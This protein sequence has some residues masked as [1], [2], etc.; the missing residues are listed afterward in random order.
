MFQNLKLNGYRGFESYELDGLTRVNLLVGKNNCGKTSILEAINLLVSGGNPLVLEQSASRRGEVNL[1]DE[2]DGPYRRESIPDISHL[3]FGHAFGSGSQF[4]L[5]SDSPIGSLS[6]DTIDVDDIMEEQRSLFEDEMGAAPVLGLRITTNTHDEFPVFPIAEDGSLSYLRFPRSRRWWINS[7]LETPTI[8][9]L[10]PDSLYP[11]SMRDM[12]DKV[13]IE[14]R[15]S[16]VIDAMRILEKDLTSINFLTG[17]SSRRLSGRAGVLVGFHG[18]GQRVPLGSHGDGMRRLLAL[19]LSLIQ[20]TNGFLLIDEI[21]T[22]LHWTIMEEMWRLIVN[23]AQQSKVQVFATTHS[24][25]CI[26]GLASFV[27]SFPEFASEISIQKIDR[28][29]EKAVSLDAERIRIAV[30]Q[31]IEIR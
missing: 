22:G 14:G 2:V 12:W 4:R 19:S 13:L 5:S 20:T 8:Q 29:L 1:L 9:F 31:N 10:T 3:F 24:Y 30:A 6:I 11:D 21:D 18:S 28:T 7:K 26:Q 17:S 27:E 16:D 25:D 15:E 23:A